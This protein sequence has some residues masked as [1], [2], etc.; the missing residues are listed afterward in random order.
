MTKERILNKAKA[1]APSL[2]TEMTRLSQPHPILLTLTDDS[3]P[4][5]LPLSQISHSY[6]VSSIEEKKADWKP[7]GV[8]T[9]A[10]L[11]GARR[12][13]RISSRARTRVLLVWQL[14]ALILMTYWPAGS[15]LAQIRNKHRPSKPDTIRLKL[16]SVGL[17][18]TDHN[19]RHVVIRGPGKRKK[20][21]RS[22]AKL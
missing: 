15:M 4:K 2:G 17:W 18:P 11:P 19:L 21:L 22:P 9:G 20:E 16:W 12:S 6:P 5:I 14:N 7:L 10:M 1:P 3:Y 13:V 8:R